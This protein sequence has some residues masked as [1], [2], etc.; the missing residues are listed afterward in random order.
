M[1]TSLNATAAQGGSQ[2][3]LGE[4]QP[5]VELMGRQVPMLSTQAGEWRAIHDDASVSEPG[6][7]FS[8]INKSF[9]QQTGATMGALR[10][11]A[12]SFPPQ[13]L[14]KKAFALY[15][16]FRPDT[17]GQWG[18][19]G[20]VHLRSV[21]DLRRFLTH[22][23]DVKQEE[24]ADA[25]VKAEGSRDGVKEEDAPDVKPAIEQEGGSDPKVGAPVK[26]E[27]DEAEDEFD[28]Y[29][30]NDDLGDLSALP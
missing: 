11:L 17:G 25:V 29:L 26:K 24:K 19:K 5:F 22:K 3:A 28:A 6:R 13:E 18:A 1:F 10:C 30:D 2:K 21:L 20:V 27:A 4:A 9:A 14:N 23:D 7:A 15:A 12:E 16:Q 8:Y